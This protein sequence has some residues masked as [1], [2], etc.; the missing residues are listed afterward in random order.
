MVSCSAWLGLRCRTNDVAPKW[1]LIWSQVADK[2]PE[3]TTAV[4]S[5]VENDVTL[6]ELHRKRVAAEM[7]PLCISDERNVP[8]RL[9]CCNPVED[10]RDDRIGSGKLS[11]MA[12]TIGVRERRSRRKQLRTDSVRVEDNCS[13]GTE[14]D[15][16]G[17]NPERA[18]QDLTSSSSAAATRERSFAALS[19]F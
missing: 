9:M 11:R 7:T 16:D 6:A 14:Y 5:V 1:L 4:S 18:L 10:R 12:A 19:V 2:L 3:H 8:A 17:C 13:E 15:S